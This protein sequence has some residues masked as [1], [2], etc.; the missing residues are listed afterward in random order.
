[1]AYSTRRVTID[2]KLPQRCLDCKKP[3]IKANKIRNIPEGSV[4]HASKG[5]CTTCSARARG[6]FKVRYVPTTTET[7]MNCRLCRRILDF[8]EFSPTTSVIGYTHECKLCTRLRYSYNMSFEQYTN[9]LIL[10]DYRCAICLKHVDGLERDLCVDHDHRCCNV[11]AR[12]CG[13][14][15]RGLLC[16]TCNQGIGLLQDDTEILFRAG[17]YLAEYRK[18]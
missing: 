11:R 12:S 13:S 9:L 3:M 10:Q 14:C 16:T 8:S 4:M 15:V 18:N 1:M 6:G 17:Q 7:T 2:W 5:L